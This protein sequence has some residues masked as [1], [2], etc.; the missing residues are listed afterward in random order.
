MASDHVEEICII[1]AQQLV[2]D[3]CSSGFTLLLTE[4]TSD[5]PREGPRD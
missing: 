3:I 2:N 5:W 4:L 1:C